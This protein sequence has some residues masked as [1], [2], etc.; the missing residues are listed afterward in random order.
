MRAV[1][2]AAAAV[3]AGRSVLVDVLSACLVYA[4]V[5][6]PGINWLS[7]HDRP[8]GNFRFRIREV[9]PH[10]VQDKYLKSFIS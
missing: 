2:Q 6:T 10:F 9:L 7:A 1:E 5:R 4:N 3:Q 8:S